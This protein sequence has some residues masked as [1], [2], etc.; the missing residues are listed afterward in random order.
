MKRHLYFNLLFLLLFSCSNGTRSF[1]ES[2][3]GLKEAPVNDQDATGENDPEAELDG[4]SEIYSLIVKVKQD[5]APPVDYLFVVDNSTSMGGD[6][7]MM[8][9]IAKGF[10]D[11][12][13]N[14][15][16]PSTAKIGVISMAVDEVEQE[17]SKIVGFKS[18]VTSEQIKNSERSSQSKAAVSWM[19]CRMV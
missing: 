17:S 19:Q 1:S 13:E 11:I 6:D 4:D 10:K 5:S 2:N 9:K 18:L 12:V 16:F 8:A 3:V 7:G 14:G 15:E